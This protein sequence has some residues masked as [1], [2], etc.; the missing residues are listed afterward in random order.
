MDIDLDLFRVKP[1]KKV[2]LG[3]I[4]PDKIR[5]F[6]DDKQKGKDIRCQLTLEM[7]DLQERL[8]AEHKH[9]LLIVLQGMDT[10]G[11]DGT[12][13]H[14]F[15][16]VNPQ[17]V[18]VASFKAPT[19]EELSHDFLWRIHRQ[20]PGKGHITIFNR[21]HYE[22]VLVVRVHNLAPEKVWRKRYQHIN[23]FER[24]LVDEG[25]TILKFFL[26]ISKDEQKKRLLDRL[27][28][29]EKHWKF[30]PNDLKER[31]YWDAYFQAYQDAIEK[32]STEWA[33]WYIIPANHKWFRDLVIASAIVKT[34]KALKPEPPLLFKESEVDTFK[35]ELKSSERKAVH[36]TEEKDN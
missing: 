33:P 3:E 30:D 24:L 14:V 2:D 25:T 21:S 32:T 13:E 22:D 35:Q 19:P 26:Y 1:G 9:A 31:G 15:E 16:G 5:G 34:L 20:T 11:K 12:I 29:P 8:Y 23:D 36:S 6:E 28:Q 7:A 27:D 17:G 18:S 10:S 4:D